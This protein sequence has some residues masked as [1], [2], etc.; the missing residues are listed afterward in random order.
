MQ[1]RLGSPDLL[2]GLTLK[3]LFLKALLGTVW[4]ARPYLTL[5]LSVIFAEWIPPRGRISRQSRH[6]Q[7][8]CWQK[9]F[10]TFLSQIGLGIIPSSL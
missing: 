8:L 5:D 9:V 2:L 7:S 6:G 3:L 4:I 1:V 10:F